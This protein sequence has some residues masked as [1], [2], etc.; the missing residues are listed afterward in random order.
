MEKKR[1][2]LVV[3]D[4][5]IGVGRTLKTGQANSLEEFFYDEKFSEFIDYYTSGEYTD[6]EVELILNGD[7]FN[8]L[9]VDYRGH[10]LTVETQDMSLEKMQRIVEG[11]PVFF[12][13]LKNFIKSGHQITYI[14]GNHDQA[15]LWPKIR[16]YVNTIVGGSIRYKNIVYYFDGIHIEHGHMYE[17][18]NRIDPKKFFL[19]RNIPEPI[20]NFPFGSHFFVEFV[21]E[22]KKLNPFVGKVRPFRNSIRWNLINDFMFTI[23]S[24]FKLFRY[25]IK[26]A[27]NGG[28]NN[29][30][31]WSIK[32]LLEIFLRGPIFPD[33]SLAAKK[34]LEDERIKKVIFG[35]S[36][37]YTFRQ[38]NDKE[39]FNT[40]TWT[41]V[42][43]LDT[44][45][46]GKI[47][48]LTYV[49]IEYPEAP[50]DKELSVTPQA[51]LKEW[52]GY[53]RIEEDIDVS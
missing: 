46:L 40:G 43:S 50:E 8:F 36:H 41:E 30:R 6:C 21:L 48:K 23:K 38:W 49:L 4:L 47:T 31:Q 2:K 28:K 52:C 15:M 45:S 5:H 20:L 33:L 13:T 10:F 7:I 42:T 11:H 24:V 3:S 16:E 34:L 1:I 12:K 29:R 32:S 35:H 53:H 27:M 22:L 37:V 14:V 17:I 9:Q 18:A 26:A 39:Y 19:K 44:A 51:R 25:F